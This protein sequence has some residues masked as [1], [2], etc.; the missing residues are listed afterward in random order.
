M[1]E[2][3]RDAAELRMFLDQE[4]EAWASAQVAGALTDGEAYELSGA[5][6]LMLRDAWGHIST[7][8]APPGPK[9][10]LDAS[11]LQSMIDQAA[12]GIRGREFDIAEARRMVALHKRNEAAIAAAGAS[13]D[14]AE[15]EL[16]AATRAT[17]EARRVAAERRSELEAAQDSLAAAKTVHGQ[18]VELILA[19]QSL[20]SA[21]LEREMA[22]ASLTNA[23]SAFAQAEIDFQR[24]ERHADIVARLRRE[25]GNL[26]SNLQ[27]ERAS[28]EEGRRWLE[29]WRTLE[30]RPEELRALE[31]AN[32]QVEI[33]LSNTRSTFESASTTV[34]Q[35]RQVLQAMQRS[36][37]ELSAAV[38]SIAIHLPDEA[39]ECPA[40]AAHYASPAELKERIDAAAQR[41]APMLAGQQNVLLAA[42]NRL[43]A[44]A[45]TLAAQ[46]DALKRIEL[47]RAEIS[48]AA[49]ANRA[50]LTRLGW[51]L[52]SGTLEVQEKLSLIGKTIDAHEASVARR[53]R[54]IEKLSSGEAAARVQATAVRQRDTARRADEAAAR[55]LTDATTAERLADEAL[56][57]RAEHLY[58]GQSI[59]TREQMQDAGGHT[60]ANQEKAQ[61]AYDAAS[62]ALSEQELRLAT[63]QQAEAGLSAR[64][65]QAS[66]ERDR[67]RGAL[68]EL[69]ANWRAAGWSEANFSEE[70][71]EIATTQLARGRGRL[72][73]A[74]SALRRFREGRDAWSRQ[75]SHR[76][77]LDRLAAI[78]DLAPT[79]T[80]D[81]V[82]ETVEQKRSEAERS[83]HQT[84]R[85]KEI[86]ASASTAIATAVSEFNAEY[87][88]P[89]DRLTK[90]INQAILCD[91]RIGIDLHV[92][93]RTVKQTAKR[94]G[95]LPE[96]RKI[97]PM[98]VH[99]EG[100]MAALSVSM[101]CAASL[102]Y[103]WSRWRA[104]ILD[105]PL[106]HN[107]S[108][109]AA[110]FADM[111]GNLVQAKDYQVLLS[112]HDLGQADFLRRKFQAR[113]I[114]CAALNL[115][116]RGKAGVE[117]EFLPSGAGSATASASA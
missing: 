31:V 112:T 85:A 53:V 96:T 24:S 117:T 76:S 77:A 106:Q 91:P 74:E 56:K 48:D 13:A 16:G 58:P 18:H 3:E 2:L 100:Q 98:L 65:A 86:A 14:E 11:G 95:E 52:D 82:R 54:W 102:T 57:T 84:A 23:R 8:P 4:E 64:I 62:R 68:T 113:S 67:L 41:L 5:I 66:E 32:P 28:I 88:E 97:D 83:A 55:R 19:R 116:G 42:E 38:N 59:P 25:L 81:Q 1:A 10:P 36:V 27:S 73:E 93:K 9:E 90:R 109:H 71:V 35:H 40:C 99:S 111:I 114:P 12:E 26:V 43:A 101:L 103:P 92:N 44:T 46:E 78:A 50:L 105:D 115:L 108:I 34:D 72:A 87:I 39:H 21:R 63:L 15:R 89:L 22:A 6:V 45:S 49:E 60:A 20:D 107:D 37:G 69:A 75:Q 51:N 33:L 29:R 70:G 79:S 30:S 7:Q 110:A 104:L 61:Q 94:D 80:R 47:L 17:E